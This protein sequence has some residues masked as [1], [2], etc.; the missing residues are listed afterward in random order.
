MWLNLRIYAFTELVL[1]EILTLDLAIKALMM[2]SNLV[3]G[4]IKRIIDS[5]ESIDDIINSYKYSE[6]FLITMDFQVMH[7]I[8]TGDIPDKTYDDIAQNHNP[9]ICL[10]FLKKV[11]N[12]KETLTKIASNYSE[13]QRCHI[14]ICIF[15]IQE[16]LLAEVKEFLDEDIVQDP[17]GI[18]LTKSETN[19]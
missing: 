1:S 9:I 17:K 19:H 4:F 16:R 7:K 2:L 12:S 8:L 10:D 18:P 13:E 5:E 14:G 6:R 15:N 11:N 3:F